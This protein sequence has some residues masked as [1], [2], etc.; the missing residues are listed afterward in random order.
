MPLSLEGPEIMVGIFVVGTGDRM[1]G[2]GGLGGVGGAAV[3][4]VLVVA[5]AQVL[6]EDGPV[7]AV[8]GVLL[9]VSMA[10]VVDLAA[11]LRVGVV[12]VRVGHAPAVE[13][14]VGLGHG[15]RKRLHR[16]DL[17]RA[18]FQQNRPNRL[19]VGGLGRGI[20]LRHVRIRTVGRL[21]GV[22]GIRG[23][24]R[25]RRRVGLGGIGIWGVGRTRRGVRIVC[26]FRR[27]VGIVGG[28]RNVVRLKFERRGIS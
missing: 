26:R 21:G 4:V 24:G 22:V 7:P 28:F 16:L 27:G 3:H 25:N 20:R 19:L 17:I 23:I 13:A 18:F 15:D 12:A 10:E 14:G 1:V 9:P 2:R 11:G 6:V 8:E 5:G